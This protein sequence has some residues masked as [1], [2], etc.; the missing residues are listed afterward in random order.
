MVTHLHSLYINIISTGTTV[1]RGRGQERLPWVFYCTAQDQ[2]EGLGLA[3]QRKQRRSAGSI[4]LYICMYHCP[5]L[6]VS[7]G[8]L[9]LTFL[10]MSLASCSFVECLLSYHLVVQCPNTK[11]LEVSRQSEPMRLCMWAIK[12]STVLISFSFVYHLLQCTWF[13]WPLPILVSEPC[14][15]FHSL[16]PLLADHCMHACSHAHAHTHVLAC[17][18][19]RTYTQRKHHTCNMNI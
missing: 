8:N 19:E 17:L 11:S 6:L 15:S 9:C 2:T 12:W 3:E 10:D 4:N 13:M 16:P 5:F 18:H 7:H 1:D 14:P